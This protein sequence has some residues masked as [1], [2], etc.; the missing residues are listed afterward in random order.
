MA[1]IFL[2]LCIVL[3]PWAAGGSVSHPILPLSAILSVLTLLRTTSFR[4][5]EVFE[6]RCDGNEFELKIGYTEEGD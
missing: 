2:V 6:P 1:I 5:E 4:V 3:R